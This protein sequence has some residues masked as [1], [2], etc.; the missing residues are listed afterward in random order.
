[1][2]LNIFRGKVAQKIALPDWVCHKLP[3]CL[4]CPSHFTTIQTTPFMVCHFKH[5]LSIG[6][7][8]KNSKVDSMLS[9]QYLVGLFGLL[10][11]SAP[12]MHHLSLGGMEEQ[13]IFSSFD[14]KPS[15]I[16][17]VSPSSSVNCPL[18][19]CKHNFYH[20]CIQYC[21]VSIKHPRLLLQG[22]CMCEG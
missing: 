10:S 18:H 5:H 8:R 22:V 16:S 14:S 9:C 12:N 1:M 19:Q 17:A 21:P 20:V 4:F 13:C 15:S 3:V 11:F 2:M 6:S 7:S